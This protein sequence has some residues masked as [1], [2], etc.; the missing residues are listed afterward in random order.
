MPL[1]LK[2][3][4]EPAAAED[5]ERLLVERLWPRGVSKADARLDG[6]L[7]DLAPSTGLRQWFGH[8]PERWDEFR[9]RYMDE[10]RQPERQRALHDLAEKARTGLV[11][12][13]YAA[14]DEEHNGALI[15]KEAIDASTDAPEPREDW[16]CREIVLGSQDAI[17]F[18]DT[19]GVIRLWNAGAVA[20]F[21][22]TPGEAIGQTLDL[23]IPERQR[24]RHWDGYRRV[25]ATGETKYGREMLAV[26]AMRKDGERVSIE[27]TIVLV[28]DG[29][30]RVLGPAAT[31]RD[32][33]ARWQEQRQLRQTLADLQAKLDALTSEP[34]ARP[35]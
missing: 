1:K 17:I 23:I 21:G 6:W 14:R 15:L 13:V 29:E 3:A 32:V 7:R 28:K 18:A 5:G 33:T 9:D 16:L 20:I 25:M 10:L 12:L 22:Y 30:G 24:A 2:R 11:T 34:G 4:Y 27:F 35:A 8:R 31:V 26:P 19:Q